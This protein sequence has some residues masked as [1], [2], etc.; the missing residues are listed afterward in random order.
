MDGQAAFTALGLAARAADGLAGRIVGETL[1]AVVLT[2]GRTGEA[3]AGAA[4]TRHLGLGRRL[5]RG[6][7]AARTG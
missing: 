7:T 6:R 2:T 4:G 5:V 3:A 1:V